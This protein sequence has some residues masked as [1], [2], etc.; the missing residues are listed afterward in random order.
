MIKL[1]YISLIITGVTLLAFPFLV[2]NAPHLMFID[3][4]ICFI[5]AFTYRIIKF[6]I[7]NK[8]ED[9]YYREAKM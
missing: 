3:L 1:K 9:E 2:F 5:A 7:R 6:I 8:V 4:I